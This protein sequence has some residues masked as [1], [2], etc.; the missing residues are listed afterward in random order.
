MKLRLGFGALITFL[1]YSAHA[2]CI[3]RMQD[4]VSDP[5][6]TDFISRLGS[7]DRIAGTWE[8]HGHKIEFHLLEDRMKSRVDSSDLA[9][10]RICSTDKAGELSIETLNFDGSVAARSKIH[11]RDDGSIGVRG[12]GTHGLFV[13][14][15]RTTSFEVPSVVMAAARVRTQMAAATTSRPALR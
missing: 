15:K 11:L 2:G 1:T 12:K 4:Y 14:F 9:D 7:V 6:L 3:E 10:I 13:G 5:G 8:G